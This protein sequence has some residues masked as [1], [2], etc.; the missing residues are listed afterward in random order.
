MRVKNGGERV[1]SVLYGG[2]A[3]VLHLNPEE[4]SINPKDNGV[5]EANPIQR[6]QHPLVKS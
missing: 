4:R 2:L 1:K 5:D 6:R 3:I